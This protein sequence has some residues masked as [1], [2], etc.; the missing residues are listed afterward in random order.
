MP[1]ELQ[2]H[3]T[4]RIPSVQPHTKG[5]LLICKVAANLVQQVI[6]FIRAWLG[7]DESLVAVKGCR[8]AVF[9]TSSPANTSSSRGKNVSSEC[10]PVSPLYNGG[11]SNHC[12]FN[13]ALG[14]CSH[15]SRTKRL[16]IRIYN[17]AIPLMLRL[18]SHKTHCMPQAE[19]ND[20]LQSP[21]SI[22][23][24]TREPDHDPKRPYFNSN[25]KVLTTRIFF[26]GVV[27]L[28]GPDSSLPSLPKIWIMP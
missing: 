18:S 26:S 3:H 11:S 6:Q 2:A 19:W 22:L 14:V 16:S 23:R 24:T 7:S 15:K 20:A 27:G 10:L 8:N 4:P 13:E 9:S 12:A 5:H 17:Q 25:S 21:T 1:F 28:C